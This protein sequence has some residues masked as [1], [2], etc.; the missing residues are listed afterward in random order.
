MEIQSLRRQRRSIRQI[1]S[2]N[3]AI[4]Q[5]RSAVSARAA[6]GQVRI[7]PVTALHIRLGA[8]NIRP[9]SVCLTARCS[10]LK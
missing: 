8:P 4:T 2:Q 1:A 3:G 7:A 5:H 9:P 10:P 6:R